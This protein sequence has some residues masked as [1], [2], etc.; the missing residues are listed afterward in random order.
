LDTGDRG[1]LPDDD[2]GLLLLARAIGIDTD[3]GLAGLYAS[4]AAGGT[5]NA[6]VS[7]LLKGRLALPGV[8]PARLRRLDAALRLGTFLALEGLADAP[9]LSSPQACGEFLRHHLG[10]RQREVVCCLYLNCRNRLI[11]CEDLFVGTVDSAAVHPRE[12]VARALELGASAVIAAHNHPSGCLEPSA[13]DHHITRRLREA[14]GL[15]DIRL[16]DHIIV[17]GGDVYSMATRG[18]GGFDP[19]AG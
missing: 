10:R 3:R 16:L 4:R 8:G 15:V 5:V 9:V 17:G 12:V 18:G 13:A 11:S 2:S 14:L 7:A 19:D 6:A 1:T